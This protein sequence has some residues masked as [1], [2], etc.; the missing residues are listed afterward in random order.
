MWSISVSAVKIKGVRGGPVTKI[1]GKGD[2]SR[3]GDKGD[4]YR[5]D[6]EVGR[7]VVGS[8]SRLTEGRR[9]GVV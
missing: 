1:Y 2:G 3:T 6:K 7:S 4:D 8:R 9:S 5:D